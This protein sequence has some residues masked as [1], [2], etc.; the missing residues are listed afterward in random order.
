MEG[1]GHS[2]R[3]SSPDAPG[4]P[5]HVVTS[6]ELNNIS[7]ELKTNCTI[8]PERSKYIQY[9]DVLIVIALVYTATITP[10]EIGF[11]HTDTEINSMF[12]CNQ[13]INGIFLNGAVPLEQFTAIIDAELAG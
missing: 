5:A 3:K 7:H 2:P 1:Q 12:I 6:S 13:L 9:W 10:Y 11:I 4:S 8:D